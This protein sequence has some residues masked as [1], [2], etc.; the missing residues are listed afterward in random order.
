MRTLRKWLPA[1]AEAAYAFRQTISSRRRLGDGS[2]LLSVRNGDRCSCAS[3]G[4]SDCKLRM[5][6]LSGRTSVV[7][8]VSRL[9]RT[10][11]SKR[12]SYGRQPADARCSETTA[13]RSHSRRSPR[14]S[15]PYVV[16]EVTHRMMTM[17]TE[18]GGGSVREAVL[19][20]AAHCAESAA[21]T[22][23]PVSE[24]EPS[25]LRLLA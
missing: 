19:T 23:R 15:T 1:R 22:L 8:I 24:A 17:T 10:L 7:R 25:W 21:P 14:H 3:A 18:G 5:S 13:R 6:K 12:W 2:G 4:S 11:G 16:S 20:N 9:G